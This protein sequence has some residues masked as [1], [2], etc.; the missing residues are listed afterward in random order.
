[1]KTPLPIFGLEW[2]CA[3][4][5]EERTGFRDDRGAFSALWRAIA[6][7]SPWVHDL[8]GNG[9]FTTGFRFYLDTGAHPEIAAV[10]VRSP[11]DFLRLKK[12]IFHLM[13]NAVNA[14]RRRS[15]GLVL[16]ANNHDHLNPSAVWGCHE[17]WAVVQNP[18]TLAAGMAP[19]L[20]TRH[21]FA[22]NGRLC[23]DGK[24]LLSSR[25]CAMENLTGGNTTSDRALFST[26]RDEPL[27]QAGPFRHRLHLICGDS[28]RCQLSEYLK[29]GTTAL[30]LTWLQDEPHGADD[31]RCSGPLQLL[32][33]A[34]VVFHGDGR[35]SVNASALQIQREYCRLVGRFVDARGDLPDW[36]RD[37]VE[38]WSQTLDALERDPMSLSDRLDPFVKLALFESALAEMGRTWPEV[39]R[40]EHLYRRLA[41]LDL[42][43]H[44]LNPGNLFETL[45]AAGA[46]HR[47]L[48]SHAVRP[49][50]SVAQSLDTRAAARARLIQDHHNRKTAHC[51]W[52]HFVTEVAHYVLTDPTRADVPPAAQADNVDE[53]M[54]AVSQGSPRSVR[55]MLT[56]L[57][58]GM[59]Q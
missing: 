23:A 50:E 31:L 13:S 43:Y 25:S 20:A 21:L 26:C 24:F 30:V 33:R 16:H 58:A 7:L 54:D 39:G 34:N 3:L 36:T 44:R 19:F 12:A 48:D 6:K 37:V 52:E 27:M 5:V 35:A 2:E 32:K 4:G 29:V 10:E 57:W 8:E 45:D 28:V 38:R 41:L 59:H 56:R 17:S 49:L 53:L 40:S 42:D 47:V 11:L 55:A 46:V 9:L 51:S 18:S 15:P 14:A 1:M 22:G